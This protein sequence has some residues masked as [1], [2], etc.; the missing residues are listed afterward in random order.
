M[1]D[2]LVAIF[3]RM[4]L[5]GITLPQAMEQFRALYVELAIEKSRG[6]V[7]A[8]SKILGVHRNSIYYHPP[9]SLVP[10]IERN[11]ANQV[12]ER[13]RRARRRRLGIYR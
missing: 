5:A 13:L 7:T 2:Q 6:N 9:A 12:R 3:S 1:K 8:A 4:Q 11:A 10:R